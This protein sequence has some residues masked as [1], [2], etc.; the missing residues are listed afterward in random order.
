MF[1][2]VKFYQGLES[3]YLKVKDI[4]DDCFYYTYETAETDEN[5][6]IISI[7]GKLRLR[8]KD[9]LIYS[10]DINEFIGQ[11]FIR[12][13]EENFDNRYVSLTSENQQTITSP[14]KI[15][16]ALDISKSLT[17]TN[18]IYSQDGNLDMANYRRVTVNNSEAIEIPCIAIFKGD[19][20]TLQKLNA[21]E[22]ATL[23][24]VDIKSG[25]ASLDKLI[26][27]TGASIEKMPKYSCNLD[28]KYYFDF[29]NGEININKINANAITMQGQLVSTADVTNAQ[30][31]TLQIGN[32]VLSD[33]GNGNLKITSIESNN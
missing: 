21:N 6:K 13:L 10:S 19:S 11:N 17:V 20:V 9:K 27:N 30:F 4:L 25:E 28:P 31:T 14:L 26:F 3:D 2:N 8:L 1:D 22:L 18:N 12:I 16:G 29:Q 33:D 24:K 32:L 7:S 23:Q 15:N 5:G